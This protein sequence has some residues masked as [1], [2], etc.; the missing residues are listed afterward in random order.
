MIF[1]LRYKFIWRNSF[2]RKKKKRFCILYL[3]KL[4]RASLELTISRGVDHRV[5]LLTV[6]STKSEETTAGQKSSC[7]VY[8]C[9]KSLPFVRRKCLGFRR[10][11]RAAYPARARTFLALLSPVI[12][13]KVRSTIRFSPWKSEQ[14]P[15]SQP[16]GIALCL[17]QSQISKRRLSEFPAGFP[18]TYS[19]L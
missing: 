17:G 1:Y 14:N 8:L 2:L 4:Y 18:V 6:A 11:L 7:R 10:H 15:R 16:R 9:D 12:R 5:L 19:G 3:I 13:G